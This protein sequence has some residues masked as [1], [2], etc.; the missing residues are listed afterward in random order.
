[1][2]DGGNFDKH[3]LKEFKVLSVFRTNASP[4][5]SVCMNGCVQPKEGL[6]LVKRI[7]PVTCQEKP[8]QV[9]LLNPPETNLL[10]KAS[11]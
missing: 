11:L 4:L 6:S 5:P 2:T 1:M 10:L 3:L 7:R 8:G 9:S